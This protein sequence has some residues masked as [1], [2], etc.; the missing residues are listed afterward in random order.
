MPNAGTNVSITLKNTG[1]ASGSIADQVIYRWL[2]AQNQVIF[3][4]HPVSLTQNVNANSSLTETI[5]VSA[6]AQPGTYTLQWDMVQGSTI[7]SSQGAQVQNTSILIARY[8]ESFSSTGLPTTFTLGATLKINVSVQNKGAM[9]W[10]A[11]G[12][13]PVTLHYS[14]LIRIRSQKHN[15]LA[16]AEG[17]SNQH[18]V[19]L[20]NANSYE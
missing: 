1:K 14:W 18:Y 3:T 15:I 16:H 20:R 8:A 10:P 17:C 7:F 12:S 19:V 2:N 5:P 9:T 13:S 11:G 4:S 6:P